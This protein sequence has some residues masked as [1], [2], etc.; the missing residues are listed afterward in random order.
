L[1]DLASKAKNYTLY[2]LGKDKAI[3]VI[4][5]TKDTPVREFDIGK[6]AST[7]GHTFVKL[8]DNPNIYYAR[9][10]FR[11]HFEMKADELRDKVVMKLDSNEISE[12]S[13]N[14]EGK[15]YLF[16]KNVAKVEPPVIAKDQ[17]KP[18]EP[19]AK[20]QAEP[21]KPEE[22][23]TWVMPDGKKG[24]KDQVDGLINQVTNLS[25]QEYIDGKTKE[26]F[27]TL[28]PIYTLKL[29]GAKDY[30][31]TVYPKVEKEKPEDKESPGADKYPVISSESPYPFYLT[32]WKAEQLMKKPDELMEEVKPVT[33]VK[34]ETGK[35]K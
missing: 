32:S 8:K 20:P 26:D 9:E 4:A 23:I 10:S 3:H 21:K 14:K 5:F 30:M 22:Q 17:E 29:K 28:E 11:N 33:E 6:T 34:P 2:D 25:C 1:T 13:I 27:K 19:A 35:K 18:G 31:I 12:V 7:Y 24:K 16:T 15:D